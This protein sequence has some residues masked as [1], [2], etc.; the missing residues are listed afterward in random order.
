MGSFFKKILEYFTLFTIYGS[1][2]MLLEYFYRGYSDISMVIAGGLS[3]ICIGLINELFS[4]ET[5]FWKQCVIGGLIVTI[6]ELITG[7]IVNVW[8]GWNVWD[9]SNLPL[10]FFNNQINLFFS[11]LWCLISAFAI[12]I[13]DWLRYWLF[14]EEKPRYKIL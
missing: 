10:S 3:G 6:I 12:I 11:L 4:W 8:L 1:T 2:Y 9:Y 14:G 5:P 13:D 7:Y